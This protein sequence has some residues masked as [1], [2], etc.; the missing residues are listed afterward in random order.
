MADLRNLDLNATDGALKVNT[1]VRNC[2]ALTAGTYNEEFVGFFA[3]VPTGSDWTVTGID[4]NASVPFL[5]TTS[6][7]YN[8]HASAI[9]LPTGAT[10]HG[11]LPGY[12]Y[13]LTDK[14]SSMTFSGVSTTTDNILTVAVGDSATLTSASAV[15]P[16]VGATYNYRFDIEYS[17]ATT[18]TVSMG[19][20]ELYNKGTTGVYVGKFTATAVTDFAIVLSV[21]AVGDFTLRNLSVTR[22]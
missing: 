17:G 5:P 19:G 7:I 15:V 21:V 14:V 18:A 4:A 3:N 2:K 12:K 11:Y 16:L 20:V 13:E 6:T 22:V 1:L 9:T 10:G 8:V